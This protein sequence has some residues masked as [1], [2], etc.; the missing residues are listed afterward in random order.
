MDQSATG[1][2]LTARAGRDFLF[3]AL[4]GVSIHVFASHFFF[5]LHRGVSQGFGETFREF[6]AT[7]WI[8]LAAGGFASVFGVL[9][10][11][12]FRHHD[13]GKWLT[14]GFVGYLLLQWVASSVH[15]MVQETGLGG[16]AAIDRAYGTEFHFDGI[17]VAIGLASLL[18]LWRIYAYAVKHA[19][20]HFQSR[21]VHLEPADPRVEAAS[22][23]V[24]PAKA[25]EESGHRPEAGGAEQQEGAAPTLAE[26]EASRKKILTEAETARSNSLILF[27]SHLNRA[28]GAVG[29]SNPDPNVFLKPELLL[30]WLPANSGFHDPDS[31][32]PLAQVNWYMPLRAIYTHLDPL[33]SGQLEVVAI[34][35]ADEPGKDGRVQA[36]GSWRQFE[37]FRLLVERLAAPHTF[38][39]RVSQPV[40]YE[41]GVPFE[42]LEALSDAIGVAKAHLRHVHPGST[43]VVDITG[44]KSTCSAVGAA[45]TMES[46]ERIQYVSTTFGTVKT[47]DLEYDPP[48]LP[49]H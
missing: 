18:G 8:L 33:R 11:K 22:L 36:L 6:L 24:A 38:R 16:A 5:L 3:A 44:G 19:R 2:A 23:L 20:A 25:M 45:V 10:K 4:S 28:P 35:S 29:A 26:S 27:L 9:L 1:S 15:H 47:F 39:I 49:V 31:M 32:A 7:P 14:A 42:D 40:G 48:H 21:E 12:S 37:A 46:Q 43:V 13:G 30:Q 17:S 41:N 34:C